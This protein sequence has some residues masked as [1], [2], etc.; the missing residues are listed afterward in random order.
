MHSFPLLPYGP[1]L[2]VIDYQGRLIMTMFFCGPQSK[3][4]RLLLSDTTTSSFSAILKEEG[5]GAHNNNNAK[6]IT[7]TASTVQCDFCRTTFS[8]RNS[9]FS[10]FEIGRMHERQSTTT[11]RQQPEGSYCETIHCHSIWIRHLCRCY[12]NYY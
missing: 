6:A 10:T 5:V 11:Q 2:P 3:R 1:P 7:T 8:S 9:P 12:C 4:V